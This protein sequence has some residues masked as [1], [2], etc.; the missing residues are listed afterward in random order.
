MVAGMFV[1]NLN[2]VTEECME[3]SA[4]WTNEYAVTFMCSIINYLLLNWSST[5]DD[6][7]NLKFNVQVITY[8]FHR[9]DLSLYSWFLVEDRRF[10]VCINTDFI[11]S[12]HLTLSQ[13]IS[14]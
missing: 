8:P 3:H 11:I 7:H 1:L 14:F 6:K 9:I 4:N 2:E 13:L 10:D 12:A 5:T